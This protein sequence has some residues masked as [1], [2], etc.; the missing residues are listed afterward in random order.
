M[1]RIAEEMASRIAR[2][3]SNLLKKPL[4]LIDGG[5]DF[6]VDAPLGDEE[7]SLIHI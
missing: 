7:L 1:V 2:S 4:T 3:L 5:H 6:R